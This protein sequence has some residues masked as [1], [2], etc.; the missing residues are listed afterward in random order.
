M[1]SMGRFGKPEEMA[2]AVSF[3]A[4]SDSAYISGLDL[5]ADGGTA[6]V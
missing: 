3:L 2:G 4:S 6:Q 5:A 1:V